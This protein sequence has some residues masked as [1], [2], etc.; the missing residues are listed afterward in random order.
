[1]AG[2]VVQMDYPIVQATAKAFR[3]QSQ[4]ILGIGKAA[5]IQFTLLE[6]GSFWCPPLANYYAR[7]KEAV[8]KKSKE[9]SDTL[10]EFARDLDEAVKDHQNGD[11]EGKSY[12]GKG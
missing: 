10:N 2:P 8:D 1:M 6:A 9:L 11:F 4:I 12:F 5:V 3:G 7:C